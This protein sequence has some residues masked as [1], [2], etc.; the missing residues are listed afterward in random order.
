MT[1]SSDPVIT[2]EN[3]ACEPEPPVEVEAHCARPTGSENF[4]GR[5]EHDQRQEVVVPGRHQRKQQH[6][7]RAGQQQ[8][9]RDGEEDPD[10]TDPIDPARFDQ[11][12]VDRIG[13]V[14]PH[15]EHPERD[16]QGRQDD[17]PVGVGQLGPGEEQIGGDGQRGAR[18]HDRAEDDGEQRGPAGELVLGEGVAGHGRQERGADRA[19][20]GVDDR[21]RRPPD[22]TR[23]PGRSAPS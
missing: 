2:V 19:D 1:D 22:D 6:G 9:E 10:L 21:V 12:G 11:G 15:Q 5:V 14:D 7:D 13:G 4:S 17:R 16:G 20:H 3:R 18:D 23:R 8:P